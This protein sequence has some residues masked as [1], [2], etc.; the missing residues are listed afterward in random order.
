MSTIYEIIDEG[1]NDSV[2]MQMIKRFGEDGTT[3]IYIRAFDPEQHPE[4]MLASFE[5]ITD[6]V[7]KTW[8]AEKKEEEEEE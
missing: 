5:P 1:F 2:M 8:C 7:H 6:K 3:A 4:I